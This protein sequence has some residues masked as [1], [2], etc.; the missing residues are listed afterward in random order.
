LLACSGALLAANVSS[1]AAAPTARALGGTVTTPMTAE[2]YLAEAPA[3]DGQTSLVVA[4]GDTVT[5]SAQVASEVNAG[6]ASAGEPAVPQVSAAQATALASS[7]STLQPGSL[8]VAQ[9][10]NTVSGDCGSSSIT[11]TRASAT[12]INYVTNWVTLPNVIGQAYDFSWVVYGTNPGPVVANGDSWD[13]PVLVNYWSSGQISSNAGAGLYT[14]DVTTTS[15]V[16]GSL[17]V[18]YSAGPTG[19]ANV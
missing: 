1:A 9:P 13:A 15:F 3:A 18:C 12:G 4:N 5:V 16:I 2:S 19:Y 8:G 7:A 17:G 10:D 14:R 6:R 11:V